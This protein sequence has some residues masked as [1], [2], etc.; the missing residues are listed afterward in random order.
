[1]S[2][3]LLHSLIHRLLSHPNIFSGFVDVLMLPNVMNALNGMDANRRGALIRTVRLFAFGTIGQYLDARRR[4]NSDDGDG[5]WKLNDAQFEKL[6][7][8]TV[9]TVVRRHVEG[10]LPASSDD[11]CGGD[12]GAVKGGRGGGGDGDGGGGGG[13][14]RSSGEN[15]TDVEVRMAA[16][17]IKKCDGDGIVEDD[18]IFAKKKR[19]KTK[20]A[21]NVLSIPYSLLATELHILH[22]HD[23]DNVDTSSSTYNDH[24]NMRQLEDVLIQC[25]YSNIIAAKLDQ[26]TRTMT[27][28]S[29][30]SLSTDPSIVG[31]GR[32][33]GRSDRGAFSSGGES[34]GGVGGSKASGMAVLGSI[35]SRD[36]DVTT[37]ESAKAEARRMM[38]SLKDF[39]DRTSTVWERLDRTSKV[40]IGSDRVK[41]EMRWANVYRT[42]EGA[43]GGAGGGPPS[44]Y[45]RH[46]P[47]EYATSYGGSGGGD[48]GETSLLGGSGRVVS[49]VIS[50]FGGG[51]T[52]LGGME[53]ADGG[54]PGVGRR[55]VKRSKGGHSIMMGRG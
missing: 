40:V 43:G 9:A 47:R 10:S 19:V 18:A 33:G 3:S 27:V 15:N 7:M 34:G 11:V 51:G 28:M 52:R 26:S 16:F 5:V 49:G 1:M 42:I 29:H 20:K 36:L 30:V 14:G 50:G 35:L 44:S 6:R 46:H 41:D 55:Q 13:G 31:G 4:S 54:G 25:V 24:E 38:S 23:D 45:Y 39:L 8:L 32:E 48:G 53:V 17:K 12:D 37:T 2:P 22:R 21:S